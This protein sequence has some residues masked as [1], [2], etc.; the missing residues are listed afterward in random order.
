MQDLA[1]L[2][3]GGGRVT[4]WLRAGAPGRDDSIDIADEIHVTGF[5][6]FTPR[7]RTSRW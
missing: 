2:G 6:P 1:V 4:G 7:E 3:A 5:F